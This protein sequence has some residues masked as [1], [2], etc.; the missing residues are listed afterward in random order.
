MANL[1]RTSQYLLLASLALTAP[2]LA[3][4]EPAPDS[5]STQKEAAARFE[6]GVELYGDGALEAALVE[7][8][9]AYELVSDYRVLY[10]IGR[11]QSERHRYVEAIHAYE[12]YLREGGDEVPAARRDQVE[13]D[14]GKLRGRVANLSVES[15]A[16]GSELLVN[17]ASVGTFPFKGPI[18]VNPGTFELRIEKPGY[19]T[20]RQT[21]KVASGEAPR[22][23]MSLVPLSAAGAGDPNSSA[24]ATKPAEAG[25]KRNYT[26]FWISATG[27]ALLGGG[28]AVFGVLALNR[29]SQLD[30]A[31]AQYP[32]DPGRVDSLQSEGETFAAVA[33]GLTVG[34]VVAAGVAIY[35]LLDPPR[36]RE[37]PSAL[38][39]LRFSAS[40]NQVTLGG[41]F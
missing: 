38:H 12:K 27:T 35:F 16:P 41:Q 39:G 36:K 25:P 26:P 6:H 37:N 32:A 5:T 9:R 4:A 7:F 22:V 10:N 20:A 40:R 29:Q 3:W 30:E 1:M 24:M 13:T 21:V 11:V 31:L 14:L 2:R 19:Q 33:D 15:N 28:A 8:E 23:K 18:A 17:G 34:A